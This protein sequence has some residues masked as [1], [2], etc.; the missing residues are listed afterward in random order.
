MNTRGES[1]PFDWYHARFNVNFKL[2]LKANG[3]NIAANVQ[4]GVVNSALSLIKKLKIKMSSVDVYD[5]QDAN[6]AT[7]VK[8]LLEY[9]T[10]YSKSQ[11]T[12]EFFYLDTI[13]GIGLNE[14]STAIVKAHANNPG[15][16]ADDPTTVLSGRFVPEAA[17]PEDAYNKGFVMRKVQLVDNAEVNAEIPLN[18]YSFFEGLHNEILPNARFD[19]SVEL[20]SDNDLVWRR[21]GADDAADAALV[22]RVVLTKLEL[23]IPRMIY[24]SDG[25]DLYYNNYDNIKEPRRWTYLRELIVKQTST[26]QRVGDFRISTGLYK[27]RHVFVYII[28]DSNVNS[29]TANKFLFNTFSVSTDP[30]T[31]TSCYLEIGNGKRYPEVQYKPN[32]EPTRVF[33]DV[34]NYVYANSEY[35][36]DIL[37]NR[38][39][40]NTIFPL[41]YF[42]MTKQPMD[43]KDGMTKMTFHYELSGGTATAY[44]CYVRILYEQDIELNR[45]DGKLILRSKPTN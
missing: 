37:L 28:D 2:Q 35:V 22:A 34:M 5:C 23:I 30:R 11:G 40:F 41:I 9:S 43:I 44:S 15:N 16:N 27:P 24:N 7:N 12:N 17:H 31:L 32:E 20:E 26:Q 42:D 18:R 36:N 13:R 38:S 1:N 10:G 3:G 39:N 8:N 19:I 33:R 6:Q 4:T 14:F 29:Q 45:I 21:A 25:V